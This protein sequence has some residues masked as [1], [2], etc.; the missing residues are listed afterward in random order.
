LA[1][2]K[3]ILTLGLWETWLFASFFN[4]ANTVF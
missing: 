1:M 3:A 4:S 2:A